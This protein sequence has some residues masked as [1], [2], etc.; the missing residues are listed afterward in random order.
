MFVILRF[1]SFFQYIGVIAVVSIFQMVISIYV[2]ANK[3]QVTYLF[4]VIVKTVDSDL[5]IYESGQG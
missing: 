1:S 5:L 3:G 2:A 4:V